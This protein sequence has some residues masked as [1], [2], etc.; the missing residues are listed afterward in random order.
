MAQ[1]KL[2]TNPPTTLRDYLQQTEDAISKGNLDDA[3]ARCQNV[4]ARYP[5]ALEAQRLLGEVYLAQGNLDEAQQTFDWVLTNDPE[6]VLVYCDRALVSE[7][8]SDFD[9]ALDCYQQA[10]ELSRGNSQIREEFNKLSAKAGQQGF[11]FSRAGLARLYMRGDLLTQSIQEWE[12]VLAVTPDRLDARTGLL[13]TLWREGL[14]DRAEQL[15]RQIV[16]DIPGCLKALL[17]LAYIVSS[18]DLQQAQ[19]L[20]KRAEALD[21]DLLLAQ[22]LFAD[23]LAKQPSINEPFLALLQ[24][25]PVM[26]TLPGQ[27]EPALE[28]LTR[29]PSSPSWPG[30]QTAQEPQS[31]PSTP[32]NP[33]WPGISTSQE[34]QHPSNPSWP[35]IPAS[36]EP[37]HASNPSWPGLQF[38]AETKPAPEPQQES[39][40]GASSTWEWPGANQPGGAEQP[41]I[42]N[43]LSEARKYLSSDFSD[44]AQG[45]ADPNATPWIHSE[46]PPEPSQAP[47]PSA[48]PSGASWSG[49]SDDPFSITP[50]ASNPGNPVSGIWG[51][52]PAEGSSSTPPPWLD[53]LSQNDRQQMSGM[54]STPEASSSSITPPEQPEALVEQQEPEKP[55]TPEA[56]VPQKKEQSSTAMSAKVD[57]D[58][59]EDD[60]SFGPAWLKAIGAASMENSRE[61]PAISLPSQS[62]PE[63]SAV[64]PTPRLEI[65]EAAPVPEAPKLEAPFEQPEPARPETEPVAPGTPDP[66]AFPGS[67]SNQPGDSASMPEWAS[68]L[69]SPSDSAQGAADAAPS[70]LDQLSQSASSSS[71]SEQPTPSWLEQPVNDISSQPPLEQPEP[72]MPSWLEQP[73]PNASSQPLP[74]TSI[75]TEDQERT[76]VASL[77]DLEKSLYSQGFVPLEPNSLSSLVQGDQL[78]ATPEVAQEPLASQPD[79]QAHEE[80]VQPPAAPPS[81]STPD[82]LR[83]LQDWQSQQGAQEPSLS[84]ALAELGG[85]GN[86][87][88]HET[89]IVPEP[90]PSS[91][92]EQPSWVAALGAASIPQVEPE[93]P[94]WAASLGTTPQTEPE[95]PSWVASLGVVPAPAPSPVYQSPAPDLMSTAQVPASQSPVPD[96]AHPA[97][98]PVIEK[99]FVAEQPF[100]PSTQPLAETEMTVKAPQPPTARPNPFF[101]DGGLETTMKRPAIRLQ[102]VQRNVKEHAASHPNRRAVERQAGAGEGSGNPQDHLLKGYQLQLVGDYDEAMKEY[103]ILIRTTPE[104]LGEV[105]S[106]LR[107]LL[108]LAPNYSAGYRVLGDAYMRQGE[109]LQAMEAYNKAL[110]MAK[111]ARS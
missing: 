105:V 52:P 28:Q 97:Q 34:P 14:Y 26:L 77:E 111:K 82:F 25:A 6:N 80:Q 57:T 23:M 64:P 109:Y 5:D 44:N 8:L 19:S 65:E 73:L 15:A 45:S 56:E 88:Q 38:E 7:N 87:P 75:P 36:Q 41:D 74:E 110:T 91:Q 30:L 35:G 58:E 50:S 13:E 24:R 47:Q 70:W 78:S 54:G 1:T 68:Q 63:A 92:P 86:T 59:E 84:S 72:V 46:L 83:E 18:R 93:Q 9:T 16:Q 99:T 95:Q 3:L 43:L 21:P 37:P 79:L 22:E 66:W 33:S 51:A 96:L 102:P 62:A 17:L 31:Q 89:P 69:L 10:Y 49:A 108:K 32:S 98:P 106:N 71:V 107:A 67:L 53:M 60:D 61:L 94:L 40:A 39:T 100:K 104:S 27:E 55:A 48:S 81:F 76:V 103:R 20:L 11:M 42:N 101:E 2:P 90:A 29:Q 4:L 12:A 85:V